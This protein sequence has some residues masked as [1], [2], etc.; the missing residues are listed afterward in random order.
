MH[1]VSDLVL[2]KLLIWNSDSCLW[3]DL[4][5]F[6]K[7]S[8]C[9]ISLFWKETKYWWSL[10]S[11]LSRCA[12]S[13]QWFYQKWTIKGSDGGDWTA[14]VA[15]SSHVTD[16]LP[17]RQQLTLSVVSGPKAVIQTRWVTRILSAVFRN[18]R[19]KRTSLL[20]ITLKLCPV[21]V[22]F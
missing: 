4:C 10:F 3:N 7:P 8:R 16:L 12:I 2:N 11:E 13:Y 1:R 18:G 5:T 19:R 6:F 14:V 15:R 20:R 21:T 9:R 22:V 17:I